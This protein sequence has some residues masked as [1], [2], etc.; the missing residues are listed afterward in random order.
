VRV[1]DDAPAGDYRGQVLLSAA[2]TKP[3]RIPLI[4]KVRDFSI[5]KKI[6]LRSSFW[7][8]RDQLNRFYHLDEVDFD[9]YMKWIDFALQHRLCPI[10]VFEG[11]C[12]QLLDIM[13]G[14][15]DS[16]PN[17]KPDFTLWDK[18]IGHMTVGG[19]STIHLGQSHH[20]GAWF[21]DKENSVSSPVQVQRVLECL[22]T[23]REHY[24]ERGVFDL[25]YMQLRDETSAPD[26]LNVYR[27]VA[28]ALPDVK[29]LLTAPS[30][31]ARP[32]LSIPCPLTPSFDAKWRD[33]VKAKGGEYWWYVCCSP[34]DP[35]WANFFIYQTAAQHRALF[36]QTWRNSVDGLLYWGM[37]FWMWYGKEWPAGTRGPT[38]RVPAKD[39][40]NFCPLP[41]APGDGFS[42]YPGPTPSQPM[43]SIRLEVMRDGEEDYEYFRLL[44]RLIADAGAHGKN[45]PALTKAKAVRQQARELV[46]SMTQY[47]KQ[48]KPYLE[49]RDKVGDAIEALLKQ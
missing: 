33:E 38:D 9:D 23:L 37:D 7:M 24:K 20:Q 3:L 21:S 45:A 16:L 35:A 44:D 30:N 2:G 5:P 28:K 48:A 25:H 29:L 34:S 11:R 31:E 27:E 13:T 40:P 14:P 4:L 41:D 26:S 46:A 32:F 8:F 17:P 39:G 19:A 22:K 49:I 15:G 12:K 6:S 43:S 47:P 18:Y 36:W 1:L 42:M 10:D